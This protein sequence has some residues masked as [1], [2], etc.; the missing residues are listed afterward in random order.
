MNDFAAEYQ[1]LSDDELLQIWVE[2]SQLIGEADAA[3]TTEVRKRKLGGG[4]AEHAVDAYA[5]PLDQKYAPPV[6][7]Y[8]NLTVPLFAI[9]ELW[10]RAKTRN[11]NLIPAQVEST[12]RTRKV[13][14]SAARAELQY[15]YD[16]EGNRYTGRAVRDFTFNR[17]AAYALTFGHSKG[18]HI[19]V[20]VDPDN[21]SL[22]YFPSGFGWISSSI[23]SS[24]VILS[25]VIFIAVVLKLLFEQLFG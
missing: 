19:M 13:Y 25:L 16:F 9:R 22:S 24:F 6:N 7:T 5:Q 12:L 10:L 14:R 3:L 8:L 21:P 11:G 1:R 2:R 18:Q 20:R 17:K 23:D 4:E 15:S